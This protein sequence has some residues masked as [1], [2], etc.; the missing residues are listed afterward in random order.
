MRYLIAALLLVAPFLR[1]EDLFVRPDGGSYGSENGA[2][3]S[4]AFDGFADVAWGSGA[5]QVGAGD[6]LWIAGGTYLT[7]LIPGASGT[8]DNYLRIWRATAGDSA[9][10]SAAGWSAGFDAQVIIDITDQN[11]SSIEAATGRDW[12]W[13]SGRTRAGAR[14]Q[15]S[16]Y[17]IEIRQAENLSAGRAGVEWYG[18]CNN[19]VFEYI[20]VKGPG[21]P[22][23][24]DFTQ[25]VRGFD[26]SPTSAGANVTIRNCA[27]SGTVNGVYL[28]SISDGLIEG[29]E[30][31]DI[32]SN[33]ALSSLHENVVYIQGACDDWI[34]RDNW[35]WNFEAEG[36]YHAG[37][38]ESDR[39]RWEIYNNVAHSGHAG[40][41]S[42]FFEVDL[43]K[44]TLGAI[45]DHKIY[46][47]TVVALHYGI[48]AGGGD[49]A[50]IGTGN[51][52][53]NNVFFDMGEA[54]SE[55]PS[56]FTHDYNAAENDLGE[57]HDLVLAADPF[58]NSAEL[59][60]TLAAGSALIDEGI[61]LGAGYYALDA[62]GNARGTLWDIG[63]YEYVGSQP[64][65]GRNR[66]STKARKLLLR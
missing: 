17:G 56:P 61:A 10:T 55:I 59:D 50:N 66:P 60:F 24:Y 41:Y 33:D 52:A 43:Q 62:L 58:T 51:T 42:R 4:N 65:T 30:F 11:E 31:Y 49:L 64:T 22:T 35:F 46:G 47:N 19:W 54:T 16:S 13:I 48:R 27:V 26:L 36:I 14:P 45:Y 63:A 18:V 44:Y 1:A 12:I 40:G 20:H 28:L 7:R 29:C 9:C 53:Y 6:T 3:W 34:F 25:G 8:T 37:P 32:I 21:G 2:D 39:Y 5:G 23:G 15:F 38:D 57:T